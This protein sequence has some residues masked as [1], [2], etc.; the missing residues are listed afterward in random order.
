LKCLLSEYDHI[1]RGIE[2]WTYSI[3]GIKAGKD[4]AGVIKKE[5]PPLHY[6]KRITLWQED[7]HGREE[8]GGGDGKT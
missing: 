4:Q 7:S 3:T 1:R 5:L 8:E 6:I 2:N